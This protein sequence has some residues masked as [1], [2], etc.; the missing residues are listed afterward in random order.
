MF[1]YQGWK[2]ESLPILV[3][4]NLLDQPWIVFTFVHTWYRLEPKLCS[5]KNL[6]WSVLALGLGWRR[7]IFFLTRLKGRNIFGLCFLRLDCAILDPGSILG[8]WRGLGFLTLAFCESAF[9]SLAHKPKDPGPNS[10]ILVDWAWFT[11]AK[12]GLITNQVVRKS[13]KS[14]Q[15][16]NAIPPKQ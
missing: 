12:W 3:L 10:C 13:Y 15:G 9:F 8:F 2:T 5:T 4:V 16:K 7:K 14:P 1:S 11:A 6:M